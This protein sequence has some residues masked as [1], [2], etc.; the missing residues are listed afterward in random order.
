MN[1][2]LMSLFAV[3]TMSQLTFGVTKPCAN[4]AKYAAIKAYKAEVGSIQGSDGIEYT[5]TLLKKQ[6]QLVEYKVAISDNNEDGETWTFDY[7]VQLEKQPNSVCKIIKVRKIGV[8][9]SSLP[10]PTEVK[11]ALRNQAIASVPTLEAQSGRLYR[12][13][14]GNADECGNYARIDR[15]NTGDLGVVLSRVSKRE[16]ASGH[17][18]LLVDEKQDFLKLGEYTNQDGDRINISNYNL[19][20]GK[21]A[22]RREAYTPAQDPSSTGFFQTSLLYLDDSGQQL[23]VLWKKR[24][25]EMSGPTLECFYLAE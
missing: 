13:S 6:G 18:V 15:T 22:W 17:E 23:G 4:Y 19:P 9:G 7:W 14:R 21:Q 8:E 10:D 12:L 3:I 20:D 11:S 2:Y 1:N 5:A 24:W 16:D 25:A